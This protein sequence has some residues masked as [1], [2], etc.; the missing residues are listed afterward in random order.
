MLDPAILKTYFTLA[1]QN[2]YQTLSITRSSGGHNENDVV[3]CIHVEAINA[4]ATNQEEHTTAVSNM[5]QTSS[6]LIEQ[7]KAI[8]IIIQA[9]Q[10]LQAESCAN[11]GERGLDLAEI[12]GFGRVRG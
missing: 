8:Q 10:T 2:L 9:L 6:S 4:L 11:R 12:G 5:A 3:E 7:V 1:Y